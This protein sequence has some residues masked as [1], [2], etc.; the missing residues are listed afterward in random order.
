MVCTWYLVSL[1]SLVLLGVVRVCLNDA[2]GF[3]RREIITEIKHGA[4]VGLTSEHAGVTSEQ[5]GLTTVGRRGQGSCRRQDR[6]RPKSGGACWA[7][8]LRSG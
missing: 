6:E 2:R 1:V 8:E 5:A 4:A 3:T 7:G